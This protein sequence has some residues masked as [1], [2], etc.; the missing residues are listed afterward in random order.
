MTSPSRSLCWPH[1]KLGLSRH[2][3]TVRC[4]GKQAGPWHSTLK[5]C[6]FRMP[7]RIQTVVRAAS[8]TVYILKKRAILKATKENQDMAPESRLGASESLP[9][10]VTAVL[11]ETIW[12][13]QGHNKEAAYRN[14]CEVFWL[15]I[16]SF[17]KAGDLPDHHFPLYCAKNCSTSSSS[18]LTKSHLMNVVVYLLLWIKWLSLLKRI[19]FKNLKRGVLSNYSSL[20]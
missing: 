15:L 20:Y 2:F 17:S 5:R 9:Q 19:F 3:Q 7:E 13:S 12:P 8:L 16:W 1:A 6:V 18:I 10:A 4:Y 14:K 11:R